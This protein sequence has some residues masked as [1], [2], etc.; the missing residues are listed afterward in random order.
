M[1]RK[2]GKEDIIGY[3]TIEGRVLCGVTFVPLTRTRF[4]HIRICKGSIILFHVCFTSK[5]YTLILYAYHDIYITF[6]IEVKK[7]FCFHNS[8]RFCC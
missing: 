5:I 2:W 6:Y 8:L 4:S 1:L 7:L 3:K